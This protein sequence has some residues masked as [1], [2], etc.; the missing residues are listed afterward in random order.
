MLAID[1]KQGLEEAYS[2]T[3]RKKCSEMM[4]TAC[5]GGDNE[6]EGKKLEVLS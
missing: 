2:S 5:E 4:S 6:E 1:A 3:V